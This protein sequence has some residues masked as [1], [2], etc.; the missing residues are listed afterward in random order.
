MHI[1]VTC[2]AQYCGGGTISVLLIREL[3]EQRHVKQRLQLNCIYIC[4]PFDIQAPGA[5]KYIRTASQWQGIEVALPDGWNPYSGKCWFAS[6]SMPRI[7]IL[8]SLTG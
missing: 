6:A 3:R 1:F 8:S 2:T 7:W 4:I 5:D